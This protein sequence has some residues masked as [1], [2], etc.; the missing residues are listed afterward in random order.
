MIFQRLLASIVGVRDLSGHVSKRM[1]GDA[2]TDDNASY[3]QYSPR[4]IFIVGNTAVTLS[5]CEDA[6]IQPGVSTSGMACAWGSATLN[7]GADGIVAL[8][9]LL[10]QLLSP[11]SKEEDDSPDDGCEDDNPNDNADGDARL[12]W[13]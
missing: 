5:P 12:I 4:E 13:A 2:V 6:R 10:F 7:E 9:C 3:L 11:S 8:I 1:C